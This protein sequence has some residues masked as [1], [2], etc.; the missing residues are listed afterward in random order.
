MNFF[1]GDL[2]IHGFIIP[3]SVI[4]GKYFLLINVKE[5]N[6]KDYVYHHLWYLIFKNEATFYDISLHINNVYN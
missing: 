1:F 3:L 5:R 6:S 2:E 4:G